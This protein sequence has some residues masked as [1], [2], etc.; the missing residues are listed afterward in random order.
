MDSLQGRSAHEVEL[1]REATT[2]A[3]YISL[4]LMAV[5]IALPIGHEDAR[6]RAGFT[7]LATAT[8][9]ILAHHVAF[10]LSSRLVS[11]GV[12]TL[13]SRDALSSQLLGGVPV[14]LVAAL[15]VF[16]LGEDPGENV[17]II[18]LLAFVAIVGYRAARGSTTPM[19][20]LAYVGGL[21]AVVTVVLAVKLSVGH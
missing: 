9:L 11:G 1:I 4:S 2:M 12:L 13:E 8:G 18:L 3:L 14:A 5:L 19:R 16:V 6:L 21:V 15:P 20:A 7:V 17:A 10:R